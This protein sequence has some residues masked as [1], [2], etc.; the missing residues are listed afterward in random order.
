MGLNTQIFTY[1]FKKKSRRAW[2]T[3]IEGKESKRKELRRNSDLRP[4]QDAKNLLEM[5]WAKNGKPE[6][7]YKIE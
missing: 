4:K 7:I 6:K 1:K 3:S 5:C 2:V